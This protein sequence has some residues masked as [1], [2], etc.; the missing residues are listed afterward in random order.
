MGQ[1]D[2]AKA[3]DPAALALRRNGEEACASNTHFRMEEGVQMLNQAVA[4]I[5]LTPQKYP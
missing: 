3:T 2:A 5:G 4:S 1:F